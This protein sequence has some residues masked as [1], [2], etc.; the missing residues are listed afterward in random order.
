MFIFSTLLLKK[1]GTNLS[2]GICVN[3]ISMISDNAFCISIRHSKTIQFGQ[4]VLKIPFTNCSVRTL[5]PVS[6][7][8]N[9]LSLNKMLPDSTL[10]SYKSGSHV[11][12][13]TQANFASRVKLLLTQAGFDSHSISC[14]SFRRGGTSFAISCGLNPLQVKAREDWK[15]NAF[16]KYVFISDKSFLQTATAISTGVSKRVKQL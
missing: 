10:F 6:A 5:C 4:R 14:H 7:L 11:K 13:L 9:H 8:V 2:E 16:E 3:D 12:T 1:D 15:S